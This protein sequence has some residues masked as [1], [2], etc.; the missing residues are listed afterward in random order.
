MLHLRFGNEGSQPS[1]C[2]GAL[3]DLCNSSI[4]RCR[5]QTNSV[6]W[7]L[8][9]WR[10]VAPGHSNL[11][12]NLFASVKQCSSTMILHVSVIT[13]SLDYCEIW[14]ISLSI[15]SQLKKKI[16]D[17]KLTWICLGN[18]APWLFQVQLWWDMPEIMNGRLVFYAELCAWMIT[19]DVAFDGSISC[20]TNHHFTH[21][22]LTSE[23]C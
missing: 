23:Q 12:Y 1:P 18:P 6:W 10:Q 22:S 11:D 15:R 17:F 8:M 7:V 3:W 4:E 9:T 16:L 13:R 21:L 5:Y 20:S 19:V 14:E 2:S